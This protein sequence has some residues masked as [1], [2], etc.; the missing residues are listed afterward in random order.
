MDYTESIAEFLERIDQILYTKK[1]PK[2]QFYSDTGISRGTWYYWKK[3]KTSPNNST[4][5]RIAEYLGV[6]PDYL[7]FGISPAE[8][9]KEAAQ[10]GDLSLDE[11]LILSL[12]RQCSESEKEAIG[13]FLTQLRSAPVQSPGEILN[14]QST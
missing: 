6:S 1:I 10:L 9:T 14:K 12:Y 4:T 3:G 2:E 13:A 5:V 11:K 8:K 7:R